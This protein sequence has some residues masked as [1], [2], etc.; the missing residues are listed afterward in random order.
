MV[1][2]Q[3]LAAQWLLLADG[4]GWVVPI[5]FLVI[6]AINHVLAQFKAQQK[7]QPGRP[8]QPARPGQQA[9]KRPAGGERPIRPGE[10]PQQPQSPQAQLNSEIEQFLKRANQRRGEKPSR[11]RSSMQPRRSE[12]TL[13]PLVE[14][15]V[16]VQPLERRDFDS[17]AASV[18]QHLGSRNFEQRASHLADDVI[19][20]E[21]Q[22]EQHLQQAFN[23]RVGTLGDESSKPVDAERVTDVAG[24]T[25]TQA[26]DAAVALRVL[27]A[28]PQRVREA[29]MLSEILERPIDRW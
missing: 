1:H 7:Q 22:L 14:K 3:L 25:S 17:V 26:S 16:D 10:A 19:R 23:R 21:G 24:K 28:N 13:V 5:V 27:L 29:I 8:G 12:P 4:W 6:Y 9:R 11:D 2:F 18:E 15:P 20:S